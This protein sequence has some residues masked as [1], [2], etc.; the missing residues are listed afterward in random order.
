MAVLYYFDPT[1][2]FGL[3][4]QNALCWNLLFVG[5]T[6]YGTGDKQ[7]Q[8]RGSRLSHKY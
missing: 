5:K 1:L 7:N 6:S 4:Q 3:V 2:C 8:Q